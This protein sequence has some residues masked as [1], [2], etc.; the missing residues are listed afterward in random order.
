[1][2]LIENCSTVHIAKNL[3]EDFSI[4][5]SLKQGNALSPLFFNFTLEYAIGR[6]KE[7]QERLKLNGTHQLL[8]CAGDVNIVGENVDNI[9]KN[10]EALL[11]ASKKF[12]LEVNTEKTNYILMSRY[13]KAGQ[14]HS[15]KIAN[16]SFE[17]VAKLKYLG[18]TLTD[19]NCI[20]EEIK[21]RQNSGNACYRSGQNLL[22]SCLL[23]RNVKIKIYKTIIR[24]FCVGVKL[25][26]SH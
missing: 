20:H 22:H 17:D 11:D 1:M 8:A 14:R 16:R 4:L 2:R 23:S 7:N 24:L 10:T 15:I 3:S 19:Q 5:N 12:G 13:Q 26:L 9:D 18:T 6:V 25:G 21:S